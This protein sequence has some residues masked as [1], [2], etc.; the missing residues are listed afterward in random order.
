[1]PTGA[2][3]HLPETPGR[4]AVLVDGPDGTRQT[5]S[6]RGH[7]LLG[8]RLPIGGDW[9]DVRGRRGAWRASRGSRDHVVGDRVVVPGAALLEVMRAAGGARAREWVELVDASLERP[10]VLTGTARVQVQVDGTTRCGC[11]CG[12]RRRVRGARHGHGVR[13]R[14]C[15][16]SGASRPR[17]STASR[18]SPRRGAGRVRRRRARVRPR[19]PRDGRVVGRRGPRRG[20]AGPARGRARR[21][22]RRS[23]RRCWTPRS[24]GPSGAVRGASWACRSRSAAFR[25]S[26]G[27]RGPVGGARARGGG[28]TSTLLDADGRV[29]GEVRGLR[30]RPDARRRRDR[31]THLYR[32]EWLPAAAPEAHRRRPPVVWF[33]DDVVAAVARR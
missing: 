9:I 8:A 17:C 31:P 30:T 33:D 15:R 3:I 14:S 24:R 12:R 16:R 19:V 26:A 13:P 28:S 23:T 7:R 5:G 10:V 32:E 11:S 1:M 21:L 27:R 4:S 6:T 18:R 2:R 29:V 25:A 20:R 22:R